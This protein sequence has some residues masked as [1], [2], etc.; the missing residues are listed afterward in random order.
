MK[1]YEALAE[2]FVAEGAT[3]VFGLMGDGNMS[4]TAA[5]VKH[6]TIQM[7]DVRHEAAALTMADGWSR[8]KGIT[9]VCTVT[10]GPGLTQLATPLVV[11][12]R[13]RTP[14]VIFAGE[15]PESYELQRLDQRRFAEAAETG[16]VRVNSPDGARDAVRNAFNQAR[17]ESRPVILSAPFDM[18][19]LEYEAFGEYVPSTSLGPEQRIE[20]DRTRLAEA[21]R[22]V[23]ESSKP[24]IIAGRG[25]LASGARESILRLGDRIGALFATTLL[26]KGLFGENDY[27][28][29]IA[30]VFATLGVTELFTQA[31]CVIGIGA[32][33][34]SFTLEDGYLFSN[35]RFIQ[36]DSQQQ[37]IMGTGRSAES[38]L[39]ADART[40]V[41]ALEAALAAQN[42]RSQGFRTPQTRQALQGEIDGAVF[43]LDS[44]TVDPREA[45]S[46][47]DET[48]PGEVGFVSGV[49]H[50][51]SFAAMHMR[52]PRTPT[53]AA[54]QFGCIGQGLGTA[55]GAVVASK[56]PLALVEGDGSALMHIQELDTIARYN[57]PL[58]VVIANNE[59]LG[60]EY[61]KLEV[62]G[63]DR[64]LA[65]I[66]TP[67]LAA[68]ANGMGCRGREARTIADFRSAVEE[69]VAKPGP[70]LVDLHVSR[71]VM[72]V[73]YRRIHYGQTA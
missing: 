62:H 26:A 21:V 2:A 32:S 65:Q 58:L 11:A 60:S 5:L 52:K 61:Y 10:C 16:F 43:E 14:I 7:Y 64:A 53:L 42:F 12:S 59:A 22:I 33:L 69:F 56:K 47:L 37:V 48:L 67:N 36:I 17:L 30:G 34:N 45:M 29:G 18:Q 50:F 28:A 23:T 40:G 13:A 73:P 35:A 38:Y 25:A 54:V 72:S 71:T 24:V 31:D 39:R 27:A 68:V 49:G 9:G 6:P 4:W 55:M 20:P 46:V 66:A 44:G 41:D 3:D 15:A 1:V 19:E 51:F 63:H 57:L 8:A 70:M